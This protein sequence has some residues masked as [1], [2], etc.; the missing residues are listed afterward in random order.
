MP[1]FKLG[2]G[3]SSEDVSRQ[4]NGSSNAAPR[5]GVD[6]ARL[7]LA[8]GAVSAAIG[9]WSAT[10]R[11][12]AADGCPNAAVRTQQGS[13]LLSNCRAYELVNPS[14]LD[15]GDVNRAPVISDDG[16]HAVYQS[17][18][19][20]D[21]ALGSALAY[22]AVAQ[23]GPGG[24]SSTDANFSS[25]RD[26]TN[27]MAF[28][29]LMFT[30]DF[31]QQLNFSN[32]QHDPDDVDPGTDIYRVDVG[33]GT[34]TWMSRGMTLPDG[35]GGIPLVVGA[36][37]DITR[38]VFV[39]Q[40]Q[41]LTPGAPPQAVY[42][43]D[44]TNM[45]LLSILPDG[46]PSAAAWPAGFGFERGL[47]DPRTD[48]SFVAHG[49]RHP[50]SENA[51]RVFFYDGPGAGGPLYLRDG[52]TT[53]P[54]SVS[55]RAGDVGTMHSGV[56]IAATPD[57]DVAYFASAD[58]LTDAATPGGGIYRFDRG[59]QTLTQLT[60]DAGDPA[61]LQLDGAIASKD[62]SATYFT[63]PA[64]LTPDAQPG[65]SNAYVL[66]G[67]T[68][69]F[70][71]ALNPGDRVAR[72]S[73]DGRFALLMGTAQV[74]GSSNNGHR[75]IF[76]YD[77]TTEQVACVSCRPDGSPSTGDANLDEQSFGFPSPVFTTPRNLT[78]DGGVV[79]ATK[80]ELVAGDQTPAADVYLY[81]KGRLSL[82]SSG[83]GDDDSFVADNSDDGRDIFFM[84][85]SPL[86]G[87]DNDPAELDLYDARVDGGF[88]VT[89]AS[90]G[91]CRGDDCQGPAPG[92]PATVTPGSARMSGA[93]NVAPSTP[94][95]PAKRVS[96][97]RLSV[98][99]RSRLART[100]K[101]VVEVA[102]TGGGTVTVRA[103]G[104]VAGQT[105]TLASTS[106]TIRAT[107][108][109]TVHVTLALSKAARRELAR[110][111]RL[112]MT[113]EVRLSGLSRVARTTATLTRAR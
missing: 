95:G 63:S 110:R 69:R 18:G 55:Q 56:F 81:D 60:P 31:S 27:T 94:A 30:A 103:R 58:Q 62:L 1:C 67:T 38:V 108:K 109:T 5:V 75:A 48:G 36:N 7:C 107:A 54:V 34:A 70:V 39:M 57:A 16:E 2:E 78:A 29:P 51:R 44:G 71:A 93:G 3:S 50:L 102:V 112:G 4:M 42:A 65:A 45:E 14:G 40:N 37:P 28:N 91:T 100:G 73:A 72:V 101:V 77:D 106:R 23:R 32:V 66:R 6:W 105:T 80:D 20:P 47:S 104:R 90:P 82:L 111:H 99:Q 8:A 22:T 98:A 15:L 49:G 19:A 97:T 92:Q 68:V 43:S 74:A 26:I 85:R 52:S 61:G 11:A 9:L 25:V 83:Q 87:Q 17:L 12:S 76:E 41:A 33:R 113:F 84:S 10:P 21:G 64:L 86:V 24:W 35:E 79:F 96:V 59:S 88:L 53:L 89:P 13:G 46:T